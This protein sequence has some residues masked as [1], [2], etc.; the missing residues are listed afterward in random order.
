MCACV[1]VSLALFIAEAPS[2]HIEFLLQIHY[3]T[4]QVPQPEVRGGWVDL[5]FDDPSVSIPCPQC[6]GLRHVRKE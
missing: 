6:G 4:W 2:H 3:Q 5:A 1:R